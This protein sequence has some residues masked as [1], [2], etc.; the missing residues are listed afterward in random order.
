MPKGQ[1]FTRICQA[2]VSSSWESRADLHIHSSFSDGLFEV[3]EIAKLAKHLG[4]RAI[5]ITDHDTLAGHQGA[6]DSLGIEVISGVEI[7]CVYETRVCHLLGY[8]VDPFN[9]ELEESLSEIRA[10]R[11]KR[12]AHMAG[13]LEGKGVLS[14]SWKSQLGPILE[15]ES[16]SPGSR[17]LARILV[18]QGKARTIPQAIWKYWK[19]LPANNEGW[20][21]FLEA[22]RLIRQAGGIVV[23]AHPRPE[24]D[25]DRIKD[26]ISRGLQGIETTYPGMKKPRRKELGEIACRL[27]LCETGGSDWHGDSNRGLGAETVPASRVEI[28]RRQTGRD[29]LCSAV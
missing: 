13:Q 2:L 17:H 26:M 5:S 27:G 23:L 14:P 24:D 21:T 4:L 12:L 7:T 15:K 11:R 16:S 28:L 19:D 10:Y 8:L 18:N 25:E 22:A 1:P 29:S 9:Q 3:Q 20:L 6:F